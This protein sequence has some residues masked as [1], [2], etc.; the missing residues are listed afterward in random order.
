MT[1]E[2]SNIGWS[3]KIGW[4]TDTEEAYEVFTETLST[5]YEKY[6]PTKT[7]GSGNKYKK[8]Y[9]KDTVQ[10][11]KKKHRA[12]QRYM[13]TRSGQKYIEYVRQRNKVYKLTKKAQRDYEKAI[14]KDVKIIPRSSGNMLRQRPSLHATFL[15]YTFK[16]TTWTRD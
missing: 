6:T 16:K 10:A 11:M 3:K 7:V 13:E 4:I 12:W 5:L 15:I 2:L 14:A 8:S 1:A 9:D